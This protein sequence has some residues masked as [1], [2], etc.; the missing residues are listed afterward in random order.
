VSGSPRPRVGDRLDG[1]V[2]HLEEAVAEQ[3]DVAVGG[4]EVTFEQHE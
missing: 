1:R 3:R 2:A 4:D